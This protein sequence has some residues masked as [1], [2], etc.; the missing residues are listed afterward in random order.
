[1]SEVQRVITQVNVENLGPIE[2]LAWAPGAGLNVIV[3][4]NASG[5][6]LLLDVLYATIRAREQWRRGN[7][8]RTYKQVLDDKL[9]W[10]F[11]VEPLGA[12]A[13]KGQTGSLSCR[14]AE[15]DGDG[16][17][18]SGFELTRRAVRAVGSVMEPSRPRAGTSIFIPAK[19]VLSLAA[20]IKESRAQQKF[21]FGDPTYDLVLALENELSRGL[22]PFGDARR[23][24]EKLI[25]GR[26]QLDGAAWTFHAGA[27]VHPVALTAEGHKKI[28][29]LDRLIVNRTLSADSVL[30]VDEPE[31]FLHPAALYEFLVILAKL[32]EFGVQI[33]IA[34]HSLTVLNALHLFARSTGASVPLAQL[35][36]GAPAE[37]GDL[38]G[39]MP[40]N[41]V[42]DAS[43]ALYEREMM[44]AFVDD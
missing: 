26:I 8:A 38:Q 28:A 27:M 22:P 19:E 44:G 5:K 10:T 11:Q 9:F 12:I 1:M 33:F 17:V 4:E 40:K 15:R 20:V 37:L 18:L 3:G 35:R 6:T 39:E 7:D 25:G 24:L 14:V 29:I 30:F 34:T 36:R 43:V 31:S 41:T 23:R 2:A 13:R 16:D 32:S 21:G 42:V